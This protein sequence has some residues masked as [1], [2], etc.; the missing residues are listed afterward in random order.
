MEKSDGAPDQ[1]VDGQWALGVLHL[2]G[3][4]ECSWS[5]D[6]APDIKKLERSGLGGWLGSKRPCFSI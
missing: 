5:S 2:P 4:A 3:E 1:E 6:S